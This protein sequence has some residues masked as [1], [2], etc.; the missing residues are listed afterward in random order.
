MAALHR[1]ALAAALRLVG[2]HEVNKGL[3]SLILNLIGTEGRGRFVEATGPV[4]GIRPEA[5][6][7][8]AITLEGEE[9]PNTLGGLLEALEK[10]LGMD[11]LEDPDDLGLPPGMRPRGWV[12]E[13]AQ[14]SPWKV[15]EMVVR[16]IDR[17]D[18]PDGAEAAV[19][20][21]LRG[22]VE[23][24][25]ARTH[26]EEELVELGELAA[27]FGL[28]TACRNVILFFLAY[29]QSPTMES[30]CDTHGMP[31]WPRL[32][33]T[34]CGTNM[35]QTRQLLADDGPLISNGILHRD[36]GD[37]APYYSLAGPV[38]DFLTGLGGKPLADHF[39][40][41]DSGPTFA[42]DSF[43]V[44]PEDLA[45][46][47][48]FVSGSKPRNILLHGLA[49]TGKTEFAR[50]LIAAAGKRISFVEAGDDGKPK[51]RRVALAG[52]AS[53]TLPTESVLVL[54]EADTLINTDDGMG[55]EGVDKGWLNQFMDN[56]S[57]IIIWVTNHIGAVPAS[58][59]R[60]FAYSLEFKAFTRVQRIAMWDQVLSDSP[61]AAIVD[62]SVRERLASVHLVNAAGI[63]AAIDSVDSLLVGEARTPDAAEELLEQ[64]LS[65][66]Q[67]LVDGQEPRKG[68]VITT[69]YRPD[70]LNISAD[71]PAIERSLLQASVA[72]GLGDE[73]ARVNLLFWGPPGTGKTEYARYLASILNM[74]LVVKTASELLSMWVGGTEKNIRAAFREAEREEAILFI[75]EADSFF[76]DR[77]TANRSWEA[78]QTNE[79][80]QQMENHKGMLI[81]CTNFLHGLDKAALRRFDWK[82]EFKPLD[83]ARLLATYDEYFGNNRTPLTASQQRRLATLD[84][85]TF[86]DFRALIG[87]FRFEDPATLDHDT[88][89][90]ALEEEVA[91][92]KGD[93]GGKR[94]GFQ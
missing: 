22:F 1:F 56:S 55:K 18:D 35:E 80:L 58:I 3:L 17:A 62:G 83:E 72:R 11:M 61:L 92:R 28:P 34:A 63:S 75:D 93:G 41:T 94:L 69:H 64:L 54:D 70:A 20:K 77:T 6:P 65:R 79:L 46:L 33:A 2:R 16:E 12:D 9:P 7:K 87:R 88:L 71:R 24:A 32:I 73:N 68:S 23:E 13:S 38:V 45:V 74:Q 25:M 40:R 60:R 48:S 31:D 52:G 82:V 47:Q 19:E 4:F 86:G 14:V 43:P 76:I 53:M 78:T 90:R 84:G 66:Y 21:L 42:T 89:T 50:A 8:S 29:S 39:V 15:G 85:V 26:A 81:C 44:L 5:T 49:G 27:A 59:R 37:M 67:T 30:F 36:Y 57:A 10:D 91:Y 51:E